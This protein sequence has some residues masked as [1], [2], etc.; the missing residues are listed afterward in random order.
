[1]K[2]TAATIF[3]F[4][5]LTQVFS[6]WLLVI[7]YTI[8]KDFVAKNLCENQNRPRLN[9]KGNCQLMKKLVTEENQNNK[10]KHALSNKQGVF[11]VVLI[12]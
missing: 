7:D 5:L 10:T 11:S 3:V 8:N 2:F 4:L 6:K 9:C 1:M 12:S